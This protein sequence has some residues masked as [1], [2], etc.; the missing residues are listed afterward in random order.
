[1][2]AVLSWG[3]SVHAAPV[4]NPPALTFAQA[5]AKLI[6][7]GYKP[8]PW[9]NGKLENCQGG[10]IDRPCLFAFE[11]KSD[12]MQKV[13]ETSGA[14]ALNSRRAE[15][16]DR[17]YQ[18]IRYSQPPSGLGTYPQARARLIAEGYQP[19]KFP[20]GELEYKC[21]GICDRYPE[22]D[23]CSGTG[24]GYCKFIFFRPSDGRYRRIITEGEDPIA[25]RS[26]DSIE[27]LLPAAKELYQERLRR[28][29]YPSVRAA[30]A[31]QGYKPL[32]LK[33]I[34]FSSCPD[35][36]CER[37]PETL[38]CQSMAGDP[39]Q[40]VFYRVSDRS[41]RMVNAQRLDADVRRRIW[42]LAVTG[43]AKPTPAQLKEIEQRR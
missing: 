7:E 21:N 22:L 10:G 9:R 34:A 2:V 40:F 31:R 18:V 25:Q 30:L 5:R 28:R 41:Y 16:I 29:Y 11:R 17:G 20:H 36:I 19:L 24:L 38:A 1:M 37:H 43:S 15:I 13:I 6:A 33:E 8:L 42:D 39:C 32:A 12:D 3:A 4:T 35:R 14:G 27:D 23:D 26:V